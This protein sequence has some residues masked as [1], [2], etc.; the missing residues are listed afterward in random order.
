MHNL[1][2]S[3]RTG[4]SFH[5]LYCLI[6]LLALVAIALPTYSN[7]TSTTAPVVYRIEIRDTIQPVTASRLDRALDVVRTHHAAALLIDLDTPGGLLDSTRQ[8]VGSILNSP[9]PVI[10][11]IAPSGAR[12]GSAGFFLLE[13][14]DIAAMAPATNAGAA[15]PVLASG[16]PDQTMREKMEND[17]AAFLR[18]YVTKRQRNVD[19]AESAV[20]SSKSFSAEEAL[21]QKL[22]DVIQPDDAQ[23]IAAL[24]GR[25]VQRIN[26][27]PETLHTAGAVL[28]TVEPTVREQLLSYL[29]N[30]NIALLLLVGG[31]LLI[32]LEFNV[33]GT[34]IPGALGTVMVLLAIFAL[35]LLPIRHTAI[36]LLVAAFALIVL[37]LKFASHGIL[38]AAGVLCLVFGSLTLVAA[39]IPELAVQP[40]VA[41]GLSVSF[42][43]ITV[44]LL[45][46]ALRA[47]RRKALTGLAALVGYP[48]TAMEPI[49][50]PDAP[51]GHAL[52]QGEIWE[53][54]ATIPIPKGSS[55]QVTSFHGNVLQV[56]P[57]E[58]V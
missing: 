54:T 34:I 57:A 38:A 48:G 8:M 36:L 43:A 21:S 15:H 7:P 30:P 12:A 20:R 2:H 10:V 51:L 16:T 50:P 24:N 35:D 6:P 55:V 25:S 39:P 49:G 4:Y 13:A 18:S 17:A 29:I 22:I 28:K 26:G 52:V 56:A 23:L 58:P 46:L 1:R 5:S 44:F 40:A 3:R 41:I 53:A 37:E 11:Y 31:G 45:R 42:G 47:R 14:A 9:V 33:P 32:Y 27:S 19:I